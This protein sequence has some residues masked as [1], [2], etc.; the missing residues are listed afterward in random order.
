MRLPFLLTSLLV[1]AACGGGAGDRASTEGDE[2]LRV[3]VMAPAGA[4]MLAALDMLDHAVAAGDFVTWPPGAAALPRIGAYDAPNLEVLLVLEVDL[5]VTSHSEAADEAHARV[6]E[7]G[8]E[9]A[10]L[11]TDTWEHTLEAFQALGRAVGRPERATAVVETLRTR[12]ARVRAST[13][14]LRARRTLVV[15]GRRPLYVAGPGSHLD[16]LVRAGG[17]ANIV[18]EGA[19]YQLVSMEAVLERLPEVIIDTSDNRGTSDRDQAAGGWGQWPFLPA[20]ESGRVWRVHPERLAIPGPRMPEMSRLVSRLVHPE[21]FGAPSPRERGP[22][23]PADTT[24]L[25]VLRVP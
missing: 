21:V 14:T 22:L 24:A 17:G 8:I 3:A 7:L 12:M 10:P 6:R 13:D 25:E 2:G 16:E 23:S 18:T 11:R 19:P 20:V 4:E 1:L 15:V 5:L 9:V